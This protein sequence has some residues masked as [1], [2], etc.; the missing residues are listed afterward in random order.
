MP[1]G[2]MA[3][4]APTSHDA[5][6]FERTWVLREQRESIERLQA[7][8]AA[9]LQ[10]GGFGEAAS[11]AIRLALEEALVNGFRHGNKGDPSKSV[12]VRCVIDSRGAEIEVTD[13]GE[14]F[15]PGSVPD[16]TAE[17]NIEIP[18]GRGIMLMRAYMTEVEFLPPGNRL[19]IAYRREPS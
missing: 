13:E 16:P 17:E 14:G 4:D 19:R 12:T 15:D 8:V 6:R 3:A 5:G 7:E 11:F 2:A 9:A 1:Q 18:S 10:S